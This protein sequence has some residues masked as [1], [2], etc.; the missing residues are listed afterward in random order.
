MPLITFNE[1]GIY[2]QRADV[3]IDPWKPVKKALITHG[4]SDH[5]RWGSE[6]YLCSQSAEPVIRY[7]LGNLANISSIA[8]GKS[9]SINGVKF[10]F[11]PAGHIVGSAQIRVEYKGEVWV[12]SGD[13]KLAHDGISEPF[14][15]VKCQH[16]ITESTF[17]L[18]VFDWAP[19]SEIMDQINDWWRSNAAEG[20]VSV[21][22]AYA[23]GKAQ[24]IINNVD[25]TIGKIYT[26]GA[27]EYTNKVLRAQGVP[28]AKTTKVDNS[29]HFNTFKG[30]LIIAPPSAI[31]SNWSK[32][33]KNFSDAVASGWVAMRGT[34][35]RRA[36]DR[37]FILSDHADWKG[38][39]TAITNTGADHIYVT[40]G[41]TDIYA[42]YLR[43]QGYD[44]QVIQT[45]YQGDDFTDPHTPTIEE[46][47]QTS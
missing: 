32:K 21:I 7:R 24:R 43:E 18:P 34:R 46:T 36:T 22:G 39:N 20:K 47:L 35:R 17:G 12:A 13:Y 14:E 33:F 23:L 29:M 38:L 1:N 28:L 15:T 40:H 31:R 3:Y 8:Y 16:Y 27:V 2:C 5:A 25:H 11:H 26:H 44:A 6:S 42:R 41:Y 4:H 10:S 45:D 9:I 37:G 30:N 19:Q